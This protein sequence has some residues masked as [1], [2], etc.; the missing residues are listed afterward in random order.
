M[1]VATVGLILTV[2]EI[3]TA[4]LILAVGICIDDL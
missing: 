1:R 2:A 3:W 4:G